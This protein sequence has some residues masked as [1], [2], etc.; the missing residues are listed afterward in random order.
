MVGEILASSTEVYK[1]DPQLNLIPAGGGGGVL[2]ISSHGDDRRIFLGFEIFHSGIFRGSE[3]SEDL[4]WHL[5][6]PGPR[7][8]AS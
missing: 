4:W 2:L 7:S 5:R 6:I 8:S 1:E 3:Q